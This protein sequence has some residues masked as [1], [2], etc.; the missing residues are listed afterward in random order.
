M[1]IYG[2]YKYMCVHNYVNIY[3]CLSIF[4]KYKLIIHKLLSIY[5]QLHK[6]I[7]VYLFIEY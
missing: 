3:N 6:N 4:C 1:L 7:S 2:I 5:M